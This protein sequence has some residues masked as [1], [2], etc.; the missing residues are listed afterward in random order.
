[1]CNPNPKGLETL[2]N[3]AQPPAQIKQNQHQQQGAQSK[4]GFVPKISKKK[5]RKMG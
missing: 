1:M 2:P 4:S 5:M 3:S